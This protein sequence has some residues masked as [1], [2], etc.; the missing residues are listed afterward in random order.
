MGRES[1]EEGCGGEE[2][3][4]EGWGGRVKGGLW[5]RDEL[6]KGTELMKSSSPC[7]SVLCQLS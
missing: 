7:R 4:E 5:L 2:R 6:Y 1:E 3:E